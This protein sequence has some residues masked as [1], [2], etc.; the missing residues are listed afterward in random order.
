VTSSAQ[1]LSSSSLVSDARRGHRGL[2]TLSVLM[3]ALVVVTA[4]L[5]VVDQRTLL[6]APLWF[7]PLKFAISIAAYTFT[8]AWMLG[9]LP[10]RALQRSGWTLVVALGIEMVII[11]GQAARG[12]RS[13]FNADGAF[14]T[15]LFNV[16]GVSI[17]VL[18]VCTV[19]IAIRFLREPGHNVAYALALRLGLLVTLVGMAV[20]FVMVALESHA[21]GV[22]DGGPGLPLVGWSTTGGDL[23]IAHFL[24]LHS[25]QAL[26]L[27]AAGLAALAGRWAPAAR[28]D[29]ATRSRIVVTAAIGYALA[30]VLLTVQAL[31]AQPLLAPDLTTTLGWLALVGFTGLALVTI[32]RRPAVLSPAS[33]TSPVAGS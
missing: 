6:G 4:V 9:Q 2:F 7:K 5:A 15:L 11:V 8:L 22:P 10:R 17:A 29:E 27:L 28:L 24:G 25:L 1:V 30:V 23:R 3:A 12:E 31:R 26:P 18:Y 14:N 13:H 19:L 33:P 32:V 20:G 21:V 16:M